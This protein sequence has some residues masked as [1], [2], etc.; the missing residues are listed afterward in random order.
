MVGGTLFHEHNFSLNFVLAQK[1]ECWGI[2]DIWIHIIY[3]KLTFDDKELKDIVFV[4]L[5]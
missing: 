2:S 5:I 3:M 4:C 1:A